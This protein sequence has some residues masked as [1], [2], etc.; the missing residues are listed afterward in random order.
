M[1]FAIKKTPP[2]PPVTEGGDNQPNL[3]K[4]TTRSFGGINIQCSLFTKK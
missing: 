4:H 1:V 3:T 2:T